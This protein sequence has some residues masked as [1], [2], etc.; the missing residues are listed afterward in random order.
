MA[1]SSR[2]S[3]SGSGYVTVDPVGVDHRQREPGALQQRAQVR[4]IREGSDAR[5]S[6]S[7]DLLLGRQQRLAQLGQRA[8]AQQGGQEQAVGL[9]GAD[10]SAPARPAD[11]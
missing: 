4:H 9:Q 7:L 10:G 8:A 1:R 2:I 6:P 11:R 3:A 5:A